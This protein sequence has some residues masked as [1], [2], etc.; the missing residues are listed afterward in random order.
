M[1]CSKGKKEDMFFAWEEYD[2]AEFE[3]YLPR[4]LGAQAAS[5][6][7]KAR[8]LIENNTPDPEN[9]HQNKVKQ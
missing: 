6:R 7:R 1:D 8:G 3:W 4:K 9:G 2:G 5:R